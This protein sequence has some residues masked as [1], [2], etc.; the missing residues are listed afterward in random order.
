MFVWIIENT[1]FVIVTVNV[2]RSLVG[3]T[4]TCGHL[5]LCDVGVSL[6]FDY[7]LLSLCVLSSVFLISF[8]VKIICNMCVY[9]VCA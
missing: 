1:V 2:G 7:K 9:Q 8:L 5:C 3:D 4:G 6:I